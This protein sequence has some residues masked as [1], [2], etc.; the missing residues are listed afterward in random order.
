VRMPLAGEVWVDTHDVIV[1]GGSAGSLE[2]LSALLADLPP[3]LP[4]MVFVVVHRPAYS[5]MELCELLARHS[6]L[7]VKTAEEGALPPHGTVSVAPADRHLVLRRDRVVLTR[8]P[9]ENQWR[10]AIDVLFRSAAVAFGSRVAGVVLSGALDDG[11]AGLSAIKRCGGIGIVQTP[12][13]SAYPE[14]PAS[15]IRNTKVDHIVPARE[16]AAMIR[17]VVEEPVGRQSTIP[18][19][20]VLETSIAETGRTSVDLQ[21]QWGELT[22]FTCTDCGGPLWKREDDGLRYRCLTGHALSSRA[23]EKGLGQSL[24]AALWAAIRQFE[25]RANLQDTLAE[26]EEGLGRRYVSSS[27]RERAAE[28]RSHALELRKLLQATVAE[29]SEVVEA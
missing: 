22:P 28:A 9:R 6:A 16:I 7:P 11:T 26:R 15:A 13:D 10:P 29:S 25:Q 5:R 23:L 4:A 8:S 14:M 19:D 21:N 20:L 18:P 17:R 27:Y 1:I 12:S 3:R 24:D 2:I